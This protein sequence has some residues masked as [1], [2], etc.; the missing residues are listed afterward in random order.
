[1]TANVV[2]LVPGFLGFERFE[3]YAYFGDRV[4]TALRAI[5]SERLG[6][7]VH[8][9]PVPVPP[10]DSLQRRQL[11]LAKTVTM[12]A[13]A[14][15]GDDCVIHLVGHS[16]GGV[17]AQLLTMNRTLD[18]RDWTDFDGIDISWTRSRIR[19]VISLASPHQGTCFA[20]DP[21][22]LWF[23]SDFWSSFSRLPAAAKR[24]VPFLLQLP[25]ELFRVLADPDLRSLVLNFLVAQD[26]QAF[27][28]AIAHSRKLV[29][30]LQPAK[31]KDRYTSLGGQLS[32]LRRSFLTVAGMT[33]NESEQLLDAAKRSIRQMH[34]ARPRDY[35]EPTPPTVL[36]AFLL[37][38]T[39]GRSTGCFENGPLLDGSVEVAE[40]I[41]RRPDL[42][43]KAKGVEVPALSRKSSDGVVNT[44]RQMIDPTDPNEIAGLV[45]ADHFDVV[46]HYQRSVFE[47]DPERGNEHLIHVH[48]GLLHSGSQFR[49]DEFFLLMARIADA[50]WPALTR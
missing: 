28:G 12:R 25:T 5:L 13:K 50:M 10:T 29:E 19:S 22:A 47:V 32:V 6:E 33:A 37:D 17:D 41:A 31:C 14:L 36:F 24:L 44:V 26:T 49:D 34:R 3:D 35:Q 40:A 46:G 42:V 23:A 11:A 43:I 9:I 38:L 15:A 16:T 18:G 2:F 48:S 27:L 8:V 20:D 1:M 45:V 30:D 4:S 7:R 39:S 21:L